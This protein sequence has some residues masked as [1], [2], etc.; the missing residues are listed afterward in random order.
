MLNFVK[1]LFKLNTDSVKTDTNVNLTKQTNAEKKFVDVFAKLML[2]DDKKVYDKLDFYKNKLKEV[3]DQQQS[4]LAMD[5]NNQAWNA[6]LSYTNNYNNL[7][8]T[9]SFIPFSELALLSQ[10]PLIYNACDT[11]AKEMIRCGYEFVAIN[12]TDEDEKIFQLLE[13]AYREFD[14]DA[15]M[16]KMYFKS[17]VFGGM[18]LYPEYKNAENKLDTELKLSSA[19]APDTLLGFQCVEPT[20]CYPTN[21]NYAYPLKPDFYTPTM[22]NVMGTNI[23]PSRLHKM[24][25]ND[26]PDLVRPI[27]MHY[28]ISLIQKVI[29][30]ISDFVDVKNVILEIINRFNLVIMK[31]QM[32]E[33]KQNSTI[34]KTKMSNFNKV[35]SNFGALLIDKDNEDLEQITMSLSGLDDLLSRYIEI[36][37]MQL[38]IPATKWIGISPRGFSAT[39]ETA[40]R[41][42]YDLVYALNLEMGKPM[43]DR[44]IRHVLLN[45]GIDTLNY[46]VKFNKLYESN[47]LE[48]AQIREIDSRIDVAYVNAGIIDPNDITKTLPEDEGGR[49]KNID[50]DHENKAI[51]DDIEKMNEEKTE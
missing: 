45:K 41:N 4:A 25:Y 2:T 29:Q 51:D 24:V 9:Y 13:D 12:P 32:S 3:S 14:I 40:H 8:N 21:A 46:T 31:V 47:K 37:C 11:Y 43:H 35:R 44:I 18:M 28:G 1:N 27:Y 17:M 26:V 49:Y 20:W 30:A 16:Y 48:D 15:I 6:D 34:L 42:W 38:Q 5:S 7:L 36:M 33:Y 39:D 23:H 10:I 50:I 19:I 22:Y